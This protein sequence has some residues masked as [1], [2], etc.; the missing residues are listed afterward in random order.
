MSKTNVLPTDPQAVKVWNAKVA[1]DTVNKMYFGKMMGAEDSSMPV[2][3]KT[4]LESGP[5]DE[6]T[7][8]LI[9]KL[10]GKPVEGDEKAAG[11]EDKLSQYTHKMRID[12][13]RKLVNVGDIMAQKR[14]NYSLAD[15]ARNR[16]SDYMAEVGDQRITMYAS[17]ARGVGDEITQYDT[18]YAGFPNAFTAPD[19]DHQLVG[20]GLTKATLTTANKMTTNVID[21]ALIKAKKFY[22]G[23]G[24][25][26]RMTQI[27]IEGGKH[28][29][30]LMG[31]EQMYDIRR[32]VGDAGWL[33]LEKAKATQ[34]GAKNPIFTGGSAY[35]NGVLLDE[36]QHFVKFSDYGSGSNVPASRAMFLGA[37]AVSVAYGM[38]G[39]KTRYEMSESDM[40]HGEE[41]VLIT[42]MIEGTSKNRF[43]GLDFGVIAVDT[44]YTPHA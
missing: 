36:V 40:D 18:S 6:V 21:M 20:E 44:A 39:K 14:V 22:G 8:T 30:M 10:R 29:I 34:D 15:Q 17:G 38:K 12:K 23:P 27:D 1:V 7:T 9:A 41:T 11:R 13:H 24:K 26:V 4:D 19:P 37:H 5:G 16:L 32:E 35:Y 31:I 43:N 33:T 3:M 25:S 2:V 28:Y 42:R